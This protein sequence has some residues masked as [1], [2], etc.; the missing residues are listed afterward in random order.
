[1]KNKFYVDIILPTYNSRLFIYKTIQSIFYQ[2]YKYW[3]LIII[4]DG[5]TDGTVEILDKLYK[6]FKDK[7]KI[8]L[9]KNSVNKGQAFTRNLGLKNAKYKFIAFLD[10]DDFW[11]KN[12]LKNQIKFMTN[13]N[14][15][16][17]YTD[18]KIIKNNKIKTIKVPD[19]FNYKKFIHNSSIN[20]CS[21]ILKK[22]IIKN[23]YFKNLRFSEDYFFKCQILKK[24]IN[25]YRCPGSY[26]YYLIRDGSLQSNRLSV[27]ISLW[28]INKNLNKLNFINNIISILFISFNSLKKYGLR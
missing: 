28:I 22:K 11:D 3:R 6:K 15:D 13:N 5:S 16:F 1:M 20:T 25:A 21:V 24:N 9:L 18:Y 12:K 4:D 19:Y 10:S 14:Y 23:I 8:L 27:L 26:A 7:K 17:T 2:S